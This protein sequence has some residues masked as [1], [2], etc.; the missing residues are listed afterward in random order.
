MKKSGMN[1][2]ML[3]LKTLEDINDYYL[4]KGIKPYWNVYEKEN[5]LKLEHIIT[6]T[7]RFDELYKLYPNLIL[8]GIGDFYSYELHQYE[9]I[10]KDNSFVIR[11]DF[12]R[13]MA[14]VPY[15]YGA[16]GRY[17]S[18]NNVI[19][20]NHHSKLLEKSKDVHLDLAKNI[21]HEFAHALDNQYKIYN[22]LLIVELFQN[23]RDI[24]IHVDEEEDRNLKE[25][26]AM[27]FE[28][29]FYDNSNISKKVQKLI[30]KIIE[31][32]N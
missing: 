10:F 7:E 13:C 3:N 4:S 11:P 15:G 29:S 21:T 26:I 17:C 23:H 27:H 19:K 20:I 2:T 18:S 12:Y 28:K 31:E 16:S 24:L 5:S 25:F 22:S 6:I 14:N 30:D 9:S 8:N 32:T 1:Y